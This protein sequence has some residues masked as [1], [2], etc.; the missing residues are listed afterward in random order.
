MGAEMGELGSLPSAGSAVG[1]WNAAELAP[2]NTIVR[3]IFDLS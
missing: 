1:N 3:G 2:P